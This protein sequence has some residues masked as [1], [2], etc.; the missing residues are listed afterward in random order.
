[1][2]DIN[3]HKR[4]FNLSFIVLLVIYLILAILLQW[5][6]GREG[7]NA[8]TIGYFT[9]A[10]EYARGNFSNAING[11]WPP[12][13]SW[14]LVPAIKVGLNPTIATRI[15]NIFTGL[16]ILV[17]IKKLSHKFDI[18]VGI[19]NIILISSVPIILNYITFLFPDMLALCFS[20][21]Y[22]DIIFNKDYPK[23]TYKGILCGILG[24]LGYF[25][26]G[27]AFPF[28]IVHFFT[29]NVLHYLRDIVK[30]ERINVLRNAIVGF[31]AFFIISSIWIYLISS[32]YNHFTFA[33]AGDY[34]SKLLGPDIGATYEFDSPQSDDPVYYAGLFKPPYATA[35]STWDDPTYVSINFLGNVRKLS[36]SPKY[37]LKRMFVNSIRVIKIIFVRYFSFLSIPIIIGYILFCIQPPAKLLTRG[38]VLYP[39]AT[40]FLYSAGLTPFVVHIDNL[41]YFWLDNIL[42]LLMGGQ[43][44][45]VLFHNEFF[46]NARKSILSIFFILSFIVVPIGNTIHKPDRVEK[47][48]TLFKKIAEYNI[49][50]NIASNDNWSD[51][52][53]II[54]FLKLYKN[55]GIQYYGVPKK[56]QSEDLLNELRANN[57]NYYIVYGN[58]P[59][60]PSDYE[61]IT[62]GKVS[63]LKIYKLEKP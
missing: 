39:L 11:F 31:L 8:N 36:N 28:F 60:F 15:L 49:H 19:R 1:M 43:I 6:Y 18:S 13:I 54:Y 48:Y 47:N 2:K 42:L 10:L 17:G 26:K 35:L 23:K 61:E 33:T 27:Y 34:M 41:R 7:L 29:I 32:K 58:D 9:V 21:F 50:G 37:L 57:I 30:T 12:L 25:S 38:D 40:V 16:L 22:L 62:G 45:T 14:L 63:G 52:L 24:A 55:D 5:Y 4:L 3:T 51:T 56:G 53:Q 59:N 44:L 46:D 20:I